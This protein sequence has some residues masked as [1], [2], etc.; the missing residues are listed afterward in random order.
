MFERNALVPNVWKECTS[1]KCLKGMHF[2][3]EMVKYDLYNV[4]FSCHI[5][6]WKEY[7]QFCIL[8]N[9]EDVDQVC[10]NTPTEVS[11]VNVQLLVTLRALLSWFGS[12]GAAVTI[13]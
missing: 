11:L 7:S 9:L 13:T 1:Y 6:K 3:Q 8:G 4:T 12:L 10:I 2:Y 5:I